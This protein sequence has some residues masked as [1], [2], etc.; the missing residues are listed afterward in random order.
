MPRAVRRTGEDVF[1]DTDHT[2]PEPGPTDAVVRPTLVGIGATDLAVARGDLPFEGV[3]G[4]QFVGIV[5]SLGSGIPDAL[6]E[7]FD[8][9]RVVGNINIATADDPLARRGLSIHAPDRRVLGLVRADGC[10]ADAFA[11][12]VANLALVPEG[13]DDGAAVFAEPLASAVHA[14]RIVHL[15]NKGYITVIGDT[16]SALLCA[17]VMG[18]LNN[19]VRILGRRPE[20][21]Q[22]AEKWGVRHRHIDEVGLRGDQDVVIVCNAGT[23]DLALAT[24]MVRPRGKIV[25]KTEPIPLPTS[26]ERT[27]DDV[28]GVDLR[29]IIRDEIEIYGARCGSAADAIGALATGS[30]EVHSL[31]TKR[32]KFDDAIAGLRAAAEPDQIKVVLEL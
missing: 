29:P 15:E 8:G 3:M 4:H 18:P 13:I 28:Q 16:L 5:E 26:P 2:H 20:R 9:K 12:P 30:V 7:R 11:I 1:L 6:R 22:R 27:D 23:G 17:Q 31:I 21:F 19:S 32:M 10:F 24:R 25:L 14:S